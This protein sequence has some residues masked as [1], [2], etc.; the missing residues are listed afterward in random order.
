MSFAYRIIL[1][2]AAIA[3][4][5]WFKKLDKASKYIA[6]I[7]TLTLVIE[8]IA[9]SAA[10][11][12]EQNNPVYNIFNIADFILLCL[13]FNTIIKRFQTYKIGLII[14]SLGTIAA[15]VNLLFF[16]SLFLFNTNFLAFESILVVGMSLYYFYDFLQSDT[17]QKKLPIHFW[18]VS[19]LLIFWSFTL[20]HWLVGITIMYSEGPVADWPYTVNVISNM[21][22]Y[23]SFGILFFNYRKMSQ[24]D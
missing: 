16:Q 2:I 14:A 11:L 15:I 18:F 8:T 13:Y 21:I 22:I 12:Y 3:S 19:L 6:I 10:Y 9:L 4:L 20:F 7:I 23:L 5:I 24:V 17:F 1:L